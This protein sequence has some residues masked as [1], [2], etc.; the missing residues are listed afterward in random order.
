MKEGR[1]T[2]DG[3]LA[4]FKYAPET[5]APGIFTKAS[6]AP[7]RPAPPGAGLNVDKVNRL[8]KGCKSLQDKEANLQPGELTWA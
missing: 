5:E 7:S 4:A 6:G 2:R 8:P 3:L 1:Y